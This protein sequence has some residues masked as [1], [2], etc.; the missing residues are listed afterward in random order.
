MSLL[1]EHRK[2]NPTEV[3]GDSRWMKSLKYK[4][5]KAR[6]HYNC[7]KITNLTELF[8]ATHGFVTLCFRNQ[9]SYDV[10]RFDYVIAAIIIQK[11]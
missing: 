11:V 9:H 2:L 4:R 7:L 5:H 10:N 1:T 3:S 6:S 8:S